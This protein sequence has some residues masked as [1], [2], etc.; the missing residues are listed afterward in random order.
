LPVP[1]AP[2]ISKWIVSMPLSVG[3]SPSIKHSKVISSNSFINAK[4]NFKSTLLEGFI[5]FQIG[6]PWSPSTSGMSEAAI[7]S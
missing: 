1:V 6:S 4:N 3:T 2:L 5:H 7:S